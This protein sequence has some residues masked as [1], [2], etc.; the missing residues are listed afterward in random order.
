LRR[1]ATV[2]IF[3]PE[4]NR[5]G[6]ARTEKK[7]GVK[8]KTFTAAGCGE[9]LGKRMGQKVE[10]GQQRKMMA[11]DCEKERNFTK[12]QATGL[13]GGHKKKEAPANG[14]WAKKSMPVA[15]NC[16]LRE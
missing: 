7:V 1:K 10:A 15:P 4:V 2:G 13:I 14:G 16:G 6:V 5:Q 8:E 11:V 9:P 12:A 3:A